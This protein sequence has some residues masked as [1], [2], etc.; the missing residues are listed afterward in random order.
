MERQRGRCTRRDG[1]TCIYYVDAGMSGLC[2]QKLYIHYQGDEQR[3]EGCVAKDSSHEGEEEGEISDSFLGIVVLLRWRAADGWSAAVARRKTRKILSWARWQSRVE[4]LSH[5][6]CLLAVMSFSWRA[7]LGGRFLAGVFGG[8]A[9][10]LFFYCT[11][12][13]PQV[14]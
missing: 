1:T 14:D 8:P 6:T 2:N 5:V 12:P 3:G 4:M 10:L 7:L 11:N 9:F 13:T